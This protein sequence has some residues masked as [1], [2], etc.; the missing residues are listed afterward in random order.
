MLS[1]CSVEL[2]REILRHP[3]AV[4]EDDG[5]THRLRTD[6]LVHAPAIE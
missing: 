5:V 2:H 1:I 3:G 4:H 6:V